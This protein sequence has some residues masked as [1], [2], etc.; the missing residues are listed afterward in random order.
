MK[1]QTKIDYANWIP[2]K[3]PVTL[4]TIAAI[5]GT[6]VCAELFADRQRSHPDSKGSAGSGGGAHGGVFLLHGLCPKAF[7][8]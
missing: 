5:F 3:L 4:G 1:K 6:A 8:L 2:V 7:V